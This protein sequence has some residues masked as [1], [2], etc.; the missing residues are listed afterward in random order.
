[1]LALK[2]ENARL[3]PAA[4]QAAKTAAASKSGADGRPATAGESGRPGGGFR[5]RDPAATAPAGTR[6]SRSSA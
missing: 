6:A 1:M 5:G 3:K 2:K 4:D